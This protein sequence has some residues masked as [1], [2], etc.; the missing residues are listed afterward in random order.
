MGYL[1]SRGF[2]PLTD[3]MQHHRSAVR[4]TSPLVEKTGLEPVLSRA[5]DGGTPYYAISPWVRYE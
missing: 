2:E 5:S 3:D 1:D 4:A